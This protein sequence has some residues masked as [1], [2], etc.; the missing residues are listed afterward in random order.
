MSASRLGKFHKIFPSIGIRARFPS[1]ALDL[2]VV[3]V[4][5][6]TPHAVAFDEGDHVVF[7]GSEIVWN[8]RHMRLSP[9]QHCR[10]SVNKVPAGRPGLQGGVA[11]SDDGVLC[12]TF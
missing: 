4:A 2:V 8:G 5:V 11:S 10:P 12:Y 1:D 9:R 7:D 6:E 3:H